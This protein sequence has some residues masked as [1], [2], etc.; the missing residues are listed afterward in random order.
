MNDKKI[1]DELRSISSSSEKR[2][3]A[4]RFRD[5]FDDIE[6]SLKAGVPRT[7]VLE[8]L[9]KNG[10][11]M[12]LSAFESATRRIRNK[13]KNLLVKI[14]KKPITDKTIDKDRDQGTDEE[15]ESPIIKSYNPRDL[16]AIFRNKPDLVAL[17]KVAKLAKL[18]KRK[19]E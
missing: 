11:P 6:F 7:L 15:T 17:A 9:S 4:A 2:S 1:A 5:L 12:T 13:R 8:V 10:L 3:P 16:D 19:S 18:E 14:E